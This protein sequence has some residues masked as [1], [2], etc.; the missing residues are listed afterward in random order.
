[1][2]QVSIKLT[3][4]KLQL[5]QMLEKN[6]RLVKILNIS[7]CLERGLSTE[8][9]YTPILPPPLKLKEVEPF[10]IWI[11]NCESGGRKSR[12]PW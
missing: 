2:K 1:M 4:Y 9:I 10:L 7:E 12:G 8:H 5:V 3:R 11:T 6:K